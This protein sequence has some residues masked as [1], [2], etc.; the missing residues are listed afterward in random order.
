MLISRFADFLGFFPDDLLVAV[1]QQ[2]DLPSERQQQAQVILVNVTT[3]RTVQVLN[4]KVNIFLNC[5]I[6]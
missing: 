4:S 3:M 2:S 6:N 5:K 1:N